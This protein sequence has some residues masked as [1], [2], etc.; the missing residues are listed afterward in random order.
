M[1]KVAFSREYNDAQEATM[2]AVRVKAEIFDYFRRTYGPSVSE[3]SD[4]SKIDKQKI[5][6]W[7]NHD[8]EIN[9]AD[10]RKVAKVYNK[11]WGVFLFTKKNEYFKEPKDL[12]RRGSA[13]LGLQARLAFEEAQR[14]IDVSRSFGHKQ[15]DDKF[16]N[17]IGENNPQEL[18]NYVR[19]ILGVDETRQFRWKKIDEGFNYIKSQLE[20]YN[21][22]VS[23]QDIDQEDFDGF[24]TR[25][26]SKTAIIVINKKERS[27]SRKLFTLL[28]ELGHYFQNVS[29]ACEISDYGSSPPN[30]EKFADTFA[31]QFM[32]PSKIFDSDEVVLKLRKGAKVTDETYNYFY[33]KYSISM[34]AV[35]VRL[36]KE[37]LITEPLLRTKLDQFE[38]LFKENRQ[39]ELKKMKEGGGFPAKLHARRAVD[40]VGKPIAGEIYTQYEAG[41]LSI[42]DA[43]A[44]LNVKVPQVSKIGQ[45]L[46][47]E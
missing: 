28:H 34:S 39:K 8:S 20:A 2:K 10:L 18:A 19:N 47:Y 1:D 43:A 12:R 32:L 38:R 9:V 41:N 15:I 31:S 22:L 21:F 42:R 33:D 27:T 36:Y 13:K 23:E 14:L 11:H 35:A 24:L 46:G 29:A 37:G 16:V 40:R 3:L 25:P 45:M 6:I 26:S 4:L 5:E 30:A 7:C 44:Y 17:L